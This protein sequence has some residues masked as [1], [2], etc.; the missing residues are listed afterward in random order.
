MLPNCLWKRKCNVSLCSWEAKLGTLHTEIN[1][2]LANLSFV[3]GAEG[4]RES[5]TSGASTNGSIGAS[6]SS[7]EALITT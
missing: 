7:L 4:D 1:Y 6:I 3:T 5:L 2:L